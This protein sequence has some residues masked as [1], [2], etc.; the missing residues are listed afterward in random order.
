MKFQEVL[1][2]LGIPFVEGKQHHHS[3]PGWLN[4]DCTC[5]PGS[6]KYHLGYNLSS[7]FLTCW[8]CGP[9]ISGKTL[10]LLSGKP[11]SVVM[12]LLAG[13]PRVHV[14][15]LEH[16][17]KLVLPEGI[18]ELLPIHEDYLIS[19]GYNLRKL[20]H[21]WGVRGIGLSSRLSWRLFI[22]ITLHGKI[23]S[24]TTRAVGKHVERRY[25]SAS[26]DEEAVPHK[27]LLYGEEYALQTI[28]IHEGP[29]DVWKTGPGAVCTFGT[30]WTLKQLKRMA[31]YQRQVICYDN[32]P[33]GHLAAE[34][35]ADELSVFSGGNG[36]EIAYMETAKDAGGADPQEIQE[37][38]KK[39]LE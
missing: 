10:A 6:G 24:W 25:W 35:L 11:L 15:E 14:K 2:T 9:K 4:I 29:M 17:G 28:I 5:A 39:Y 1:Q 33:D 30:E 31:K 21:W 8:R 19:R 13:V 34:R 37:L 26:V 12:Q 36:T 20:D 23:V 18:N 32:T 22:P 3:R 27:H 16:I 38:R 7:G